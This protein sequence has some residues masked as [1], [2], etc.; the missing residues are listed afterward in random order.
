[1]LR[2][3]SVDGWSVS[4]ASQQF[5]FSRPSFYLAQSEFDRAGLPGFIPKRR[6]PQ[7]AHKLS[8]KVMALLE[9]RRN[10]DPSLHTSDLVQI[11]KDEFDIDIHKRSI[12]RAFNRAKKKPKM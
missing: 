10:D 1:M 12:E 9:K 11:A 7:S 8:S 5:G 3:V 6:G 4:K 2:R